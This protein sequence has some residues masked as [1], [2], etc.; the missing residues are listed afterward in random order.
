MVVTPFTQ[1]Q[2]ALIFVNWHY[3][4]TCHAKKEIYDS[5]SA[6]TFDKTV[7]RYDS[8]R[9]NAGMEVLYAYN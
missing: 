6:L 5:A 3:S 7:F 9:K 2:S 1:V 4:I 8:M